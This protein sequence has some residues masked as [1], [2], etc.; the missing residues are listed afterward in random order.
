M[1]AWKSQHGKSL[2]NGSSTIKKK[3]F[4]GKGI[5]S[6]L[7][8][9]TFLRSV[10][11]NLLFFTVIYIAVFQRKPPQYYAPSV[12]YPADRY[13]L[14]ELLNVSAILNPDEA[15]DDETLKNLPYSFAKTFMG[16]E[17]F[18][19]AR[20]HRSLLH[21]AA[22][23]H[24]FQIFNRDTNSVFNSSLLNDVSIP[25]TLSIQICP[26][27]ASEIQKNADEMYR[28]RI[29]N[30][31]RSRKF[32][33]IFMFPCSTSDTSASTARSFIE[34]LQ[35]S[36]I[37]VRFQIFEVEQSISDQDS[38][39]Y[40]FHAASNLIVD[41]LSSDGAL[42]AL[43]STSK[44]GVLIDDKLNSFMK[45]DSF[46]HALPTRSF[47]KKNPLTHTIDGL[48]L[49]KET[50]CN[51]KAYGKG[52]GA[53][54]IC[55]NALPRTAHCWILSIGCSN[56]WDF[57]RDVVEM[58]KCNIHVFDCSGSFIVPK[59]LV[60]RVTFTKICIGAVSGQRA[61]GFNRNQT[62]EF[63][64]WNEIM[65]ITAKLN[66]LRSP[67][68]PD[69]MKLDVEGWEFPTLKSLTHLPRSNRNL[70]PKQM[71]V[72]IHAATNLQVGAPYVL[73]PGRG[74]GK[75]VAFSEDVQNLL[76]Q[77]KKL[78]FEMVYRADNPYCG[79]CSE[80]NFLQTSSFP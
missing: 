18:C 58:T 6:K 52:D 9:P 25:D 22:S 46:R 49:A 72:E 24:R 63:R 21:S 3:Q 35:N 51:F 7:L 29:H 34:K 30:T 78:G 27:D 55:E 15:V 16:Q 56:R 62:V 53:K 37:S 14:P 4:K 79:H 76:K 59:D 2:D 36:F 12:L 54:V 42:A 48:G 1:V 40:V 32:N 80:V 70:L 26:N 50:C 47:Y 77:M 10:G 28:Q 71:V 11:I 69:V 19:A 17:R 23:T 75:Y 45:V 68:A 65:D 8:N 64:K 67:T 66:G 61:V 41:M 33:R 74:G 39:L 13:K 73:G 38:R 5:C 44:R 31:L 20:P 43:M 60:G 57:E